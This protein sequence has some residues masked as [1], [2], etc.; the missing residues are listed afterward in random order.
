ML[1]NLTEDHLDRYPSFEDYISTK[2]RIFENQS[3]NDIAVLNFDDSRIR[4]MAPAT[5]AEPF[6]FSTKKHLVPGAYF[7]GQ[8]QFCH[9]SSHRASISLSDAALQGE[10]NRENM[11]AAVSV[12]L[13]CGLPVDKISQAATGFSGL[14]H[15]MEYVAKINNIKFINDS[16]GTNVG[17]CVKSLSSIKD[18]PVILIAGGKDKGGSYIPLKKAVREKVKAL[19]LIGEAKERMKEEFGTEVPTFITDSLESAVF[20]A[21]SRAVG[22]DTILLSPACSSFD[23]FDNYEQ[24]G[25]RFKKIVKTLLN[26]N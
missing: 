16:K 26:S 21:F 8:L 24:R 19:I 22:G 10:H 17:A 2:M 1:L 20:E 25:D 15:R 13:L 4:S 3:A 14:P 11:L 9:G 18:G 5:C 23:M 7:N 6:F 12:A